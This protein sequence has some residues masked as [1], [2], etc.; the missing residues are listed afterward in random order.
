MATRPKSLGQLL[1]DSGRLRP[2]DLQAALEEQG[3]SSLRLGDI[4]VG[5]GYVDDEAV[6][7]T[8]ATQ[9]RLLSPKAL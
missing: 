1:V 2:R 4:L 7:Q 5:R 6:T 8:L 3:G 9:L